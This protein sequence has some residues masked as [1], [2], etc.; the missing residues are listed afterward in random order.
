MLS[1]SIGM[2]SLPF[3][4]NAFQRNGLNRAS[5]DDVALRGAADETERI[6]RRHRQRRTCLVDENG[7]IIVIDDADADDA[8]MNSCVRRPDD[9]GIT[10]P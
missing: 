5:G 9:E 10:D 7:P 3:I 1:M 8:I 6:A 2:D 4:V